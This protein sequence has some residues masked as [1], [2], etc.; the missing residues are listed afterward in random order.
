MRKLLLLAGLGSGLVAGI[1][2][3]QTAALPSYESLKFPPLRAVRIPDVATFTLPNGMKLYLLENHELP[4]VRGVALVRTG[5]LF[6]PAAKIGLATVTGMVMRSGGTASK[7]G[8]QIDE[9][10]ENIAASVETQIQETYGD[11]TFSAL[12]ENTAEVLSAFHDVLTQPA[13]RQDK[14]DLAKTELKSGISRRND[15]PHGISEREFLEHVYGNDTPYGWRMEYATVDRI[16]REDLVAFYQ[17]YY[18]PANVMLAV[19]GDFSIPEMKANLEKLF[20]D[21]TAQQPPVPAF[22]AV[23]SK[24]V[25]GVYLATKTDVTQTFFDVGH[26]GGILRD[27]DYP[28]LEVMA[29]IL[30]GGFRSRLF[31]RVRTQMGAAYS[32]SAN[33]GA[34]FDHPGTFQV[35]AS[36]KSGS[37]ADT[38]KAVKEEIEKMRT[39]EVTDRELAS[40]KESVA[41]SFVFNF[42]TPA[43]TLNRMLFYDYYGYPKDFINQYLA[44]IQKVTKADILRVAREHLK[45]KDSTIVAVGN[46]A[47][48][49]QP[50]SVLGPVTPID[51]AIPAPPGEA[52]GP[53]KP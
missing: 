3:A 53:H 6:D 23:S 31:Q 33:W 16:T 5:N 7:T 43:K 42:D 12:R 30:G 8:D 40:S 51:L 20:A 45:P 36:T 50:L 22:P 4:L 24:P 9:S 47:G 52:G 27:P 21:W 35:S 44:G 1:L 29:D 13:F 11:A 49:G 28:A 48:F 15:D 39:A 38:L 19:Q 26:L 34:N 46:P 41:N 17:R 25:P 18:F 14:L 10:L 37:T 32:I 2:Q